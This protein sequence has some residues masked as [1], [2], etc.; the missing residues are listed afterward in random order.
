M[1]DANAAAIR[2]VDAS[3]ELA[4]SGGKLVVRGKAAAEQFRRFVCSL[5]GAPEI[6]MVGDHHRPL[7]MRVE[8][9]DE[10]D[11]IAVQLFPIAQDEDQSLWANMGVI[12]GL[13]PSE[14][15]LIKLLVG[16][17]NIKTLSED[18]GISVETARTHVRRSYLKIG[19]SNR[20]QLFA[21]VAPYRL[22]G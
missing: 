10:T 11:V 2:L 7:L 4:L 14:D 15:R 8:R 17:A 3:D 5:D 13:T 12:F 19:V 9:V 22:K 20:E 6:H 16:G 18:L 1:L 21:A